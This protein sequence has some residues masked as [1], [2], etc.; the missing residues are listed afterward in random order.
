MLELANAVKSIKKRIEVEVRCNKLTL[1]QTMFGS[2][3]QTAAIKGYQTLFQ[4]VPSH[5]IVRFTNEA[6]QT[7]INVFTKKITFLDLT[8]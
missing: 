8:L 4:K 2:Q 5:Y 3:I 6:T 1:E 7:K